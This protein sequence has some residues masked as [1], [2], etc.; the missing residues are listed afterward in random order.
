M[1]GTLSCSVETAQ[2]RWLKRFLLRQGAT[3][4]RSVTG[5]TPIGYALCGAAIAQS[6]GCLSLWTAGQP[7]PVLVIDGIT[8]S[9]ISPKMTQRRLEH[10]G[11]Q[12][13]IHVVEIAK[14]ASVSGL[15]A[16]EAA[17]S[18]DC[19]IGEERSS[20]HLSPVSKLASVGV[21]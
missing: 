4:A 5:A 6:G 7:G 10:L 17:A 1:P 18:G 20:S 9:Y 13:S 15:R 19:L 16:I 2:R 3:G 21:A 12:A 14:T 8:A 11:V